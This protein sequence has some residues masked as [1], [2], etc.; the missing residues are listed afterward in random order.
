MT[1]DQIIQTMVSKAEAKATAMG[2]QP[3]DPWGISAWLVDTA[4]DMLQELGIDSVD[5]IVEAAEE[6]F[7]R[8]IRPIDLPGIP[9]FIEPAVDR[10]L[11]SAISAAI[12]AAATQMGSAS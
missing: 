2:Q 11:K 3:G 1:K 10:A 4:Y 12:R 9:N 5:E 7:D 8:F 6:L